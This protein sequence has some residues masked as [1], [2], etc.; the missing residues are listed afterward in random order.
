M[1]REL[2]RF[3][4]DGRH[5][6]PLAAW[7][8]GGAVPGTWAA[9]SALASSSTADPPSGRATDPVLMAARLRCQYGCRRYLTSR[10]DNSRHLLSGMAAE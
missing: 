10:P 9:L 6:E 1:V 7:P 5:E 3:R 4:L 2:H 8:P